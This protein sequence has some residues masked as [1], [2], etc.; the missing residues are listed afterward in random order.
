MDFSD[1]NGY[2][3]WVSMLGTRS[4]LC[5]PDCTYI[6]GSKWRGN[7]QKVAIQI[8]FCSM[9]TGPVPNYAKLVYDLFHCT[10]PFFLHNSPPS[11]LIPLVVLK[12]KESRLIYSL[13]AAAMIQEVACSHILKGTLGNNSP[14][15]LM[16]CYPLSSLFWFFWRSGIVCST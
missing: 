15:P 3:S 6:P 10:C 5:A 16:V 7:C 14:E 1:D 12:G 4:M 11:S 13:L 9:R 8:Q 2:V